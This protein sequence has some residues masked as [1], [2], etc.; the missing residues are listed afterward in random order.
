M[1]DIEPASRTSA[2]TVAQVCFSRAEG[3]LEG[4]VAE[5]AIRFANEGFRSVCI[6]PEGS[7]VEK[8]IRASG[9]DVEICSV[10][11]KGR[12]FDK[13]ASAALTTTFQKYSITNV[14]LHSLRDIWLVYPALWGRRSTRLIGICHMFIRNVNKRDPLHRILYRRFQHVVALCESQRAELLKC[15]PL[16]PVKCSVIPNG[17]DTQRFRPMRPSIE[18]RQQWKVASGQLVLGYVGRLDRQKGLLELVEAMSLLEAKGR[19]KLVIVGDETLGEPGFKKELEQLIERLSLSNQIVLVPARSD[20]PEVM[21]SF[22]IFVMP[23]YEEA[24][25]KVLIEAM[26]CGLPCIST[27]AGGPVEILKNGIIGLLTQP[28]SATALAATIVTLIQ[29]KALRQKLGALARQT[30]VE[31]YD[32]QTVLNKLQSIILGQ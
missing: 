19:P 12:Y 9:A 2:E 17:V 18:L 29:D 28:K 1:T 20:V 6:C 4:S 32:S 21:N 16:K 7:F 5:L 22:D 13:K 11:A 10:E 23:S 8:R 31:E 26:A 25:G 27:N 14:V 24:F 3:G 15:V 30:V